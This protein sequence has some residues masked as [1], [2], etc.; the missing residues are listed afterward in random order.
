MDTVIVTSIVRDIVS[1]APACA[2]KL[3]RAYWRDVQA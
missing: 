2:P 1:I 3:H